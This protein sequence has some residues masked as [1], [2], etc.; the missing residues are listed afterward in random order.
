MPDSPPKV[1]L[2]TGTPPP[3][4]LCACVA[5]HALPEAHGPGCDRSLHPYVGF[6]SWA[7]VKAA[8]KYLSGSRGG[9]PGDAR[10]ELSCLVSLAAEAQSQLPEAIS[11]AR[12]L[13]NPAENGH[14]FR[15]KADK[16]P[17]LSGQGS[18]AIRT[19]FR[20]KADSSPEPRGVGGPRS[21]KQGTWPS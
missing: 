13:R 8:V 3:G 2:G 17:E 9:P 4:P 19:R 15:G 18:G 16:V 21:T 10:A 6:D 1:R 20:L 7:L 5:A 14:R 12:E 11:D